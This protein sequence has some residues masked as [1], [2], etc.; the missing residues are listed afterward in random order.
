MNAICM[1]CDRVLTTTDTAADRY[2]RLCQDC[3]TQWEQEAGAPLKRYPNPG[4]VCTACGMG[5][6]GLTGFDRHRRDKRCLSPA[7]IM[8]Q[9]HPLVLKTGIWISELSW[10]TEIP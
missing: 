2:T 3:W 7:K 6:G 4:T 5:F 9:K 8:A 1:N 10:N